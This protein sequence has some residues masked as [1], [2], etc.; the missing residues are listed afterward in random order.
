MVDE[1]S[2][3]VPGLNFAFSNNRNPRFIK[4]NVSSVNGVVKST[5]KNRFFITVP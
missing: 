4:G 2:S 3:T 5:K 1:F